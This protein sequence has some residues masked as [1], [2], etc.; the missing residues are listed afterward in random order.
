MNH[1]IGP[2]ALFL[3]TL[4]DLA[5][6]SSSSDPYELLGAAGLIRKLLL[7]DFPLVDRV[8]RTHRLKLRFLVPKAASLETLERYE[9][10]YYDVLDGLDPAVQEMFPD[11][12]HLVG[13]DGFLDSMVCYVFGQ[14]VSVRDIVTFEANVAG[15]VHAPNA[16][17]TEPH[18]QLDALRQQVVVK[19]QSVSLY[20]LRNIAK[21][22]L[23]ALGPLKE[24]IERSRAG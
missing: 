11:E 19:G 21:I 4:D 3:R 17:D 24:A 20:H 10:T 2:E 7:D 14:S 23:N 8:N 5:S 22:V 13:R 18:K 12:S 16:P 1:L 6:R 15:G 9:T